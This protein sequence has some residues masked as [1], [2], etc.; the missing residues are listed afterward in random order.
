MD[1][2]SQEYKQYVLNTLE[3]YRNNGKKTVLLFNDAYYPIIDGVVTV[4]HNFALSLMQH[5][6]VIAC[7][8]AHN[9][10]IVL[11]KY[12]VI[13]CKS[14][15]Y[16]FVNYDLAHPFGDKRF[17][18]LMQQVK[19]D[20]V[21][22]HSP[23]T[24][25]KFAVKYARKHNLPAVATFHSQFKRDFLRSTHS[26][27]LTAILLSGVMRIFNS[28]QCVYTMHAYSKQTLI[29]YGYKGE[30][31]LLPN[32]TSFTYPQNP[33]ELIDNINAKYNLQG[34]QNVLLFV[35]R[36]TKLKNIF[37]IMDV[38]SE[39]K[40]RD[41]PFHMVYVGDGPDGDEL[42][43]KANKLGLDNNITFAGKIS[44]KTMLQAFYL[45]SDLFVFPSNYDVSSIVQIEAASQKLCGLYL[46]GSVTSCTVTD[47]ETGFLCEENVEQ[48][49]DKIVEI[50]SDKDNLN[51]VRQGAFERLYITWQQVADKTYEDYLNLLPPKR[52]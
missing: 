49:A 20:Y 35:G 45:R 52:K 18:K 38:L 42:K 39:L 34:K 44:D 25:G 16:K 10:D 19:A 24:M 28:V 2:R 48:Y 13:G 36:L 32:A 12:L 3:E 47:N 17:V 1:I 30:V 21:H 7:V 43:K 11:Q 41:F 37:F 29:S 23:F 6:N 46:K 9:N 40:K 33:Q 8:P 31:K 27:L 51:R 5:V 22:I 50:L 14:T 15:Y 4:M 26:R